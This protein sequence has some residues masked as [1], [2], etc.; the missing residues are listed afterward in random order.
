M[1]EIIDLTVTSKGG[2]FLQEGKV[3]IDGV[4]TNK[5]IQVQSHTILKEEELIKLIK[6]ELKYGINT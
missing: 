6:K 5:K 2:S 4:D 1:I 3:Y